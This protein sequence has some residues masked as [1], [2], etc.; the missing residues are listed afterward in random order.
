MGS[1]VDISRS[2]I[3]AGLLASLLCAGMPSRASFRLHGALSAPASSTPSAVATSQ[4]TGAL[5]DF[6]SR[7]AVVDDADDFSEPL[8]LYAQGTIVFVGDCPDA[9]ASGPVAVLPFSASLLKQETRRNC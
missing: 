1:R 6:G 9:S 2:L 8:G 5:A 7:S 3:I 4:R